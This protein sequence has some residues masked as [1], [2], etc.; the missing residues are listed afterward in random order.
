MHSCKAIEISASRSGKSHVNCPRPSHRHSES[1]KTFSDHSH[2]C[3]LQNQPK[4]IRLQ[5]GCARRSSLRLL[6]TTE[7]FRDYFLIFV[8]DGHGSGLS[9]LTLREIPLQWMVTTRCN[10][11]FSTISHVP[12]VTSLVKRKDWKLRVYRWTQRNM[13]LTLVLTLEISEKAVQVPYLRC[14]CD[15]I[16]D[17]ANIKGRSGS[18]LD[19]Y[20]A[21][22]RVRY[23]PSV[24]CRQTKRR[25][26]RKSRDFEFWASRTKSAWW[27]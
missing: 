26:L 27:Q 7:P 3:Y 13:C 1:V 15:V 8:S 12:S 17:F 19:V 18:F 6:R 4:T 24:N 25:V 16:G 11:V 5:N 23:D 21:A 2:F 9:W 22:K 10:K 14:R 20:A